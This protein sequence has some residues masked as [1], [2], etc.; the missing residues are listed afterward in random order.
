MIG[1]DSASLRQMIAAEIQRQMPM[2]WA[3]VSAVQIDGGTVNLE[4]GAGIIESVP[5]SSGYPKRQV[6]DVVLALRSPSGNWEVVIKSTDLVAPDYVTADQMESA[7]DDL[8]AD[9]TVPTPETTFGSAAPGAG[10]TQATEVWFQ[11]DGAGKKRTYLRNA[12][13]PP[14]SSPPPKRVAPKSV[15]INPSARGSWRSSGQTDGAVWAGTWT[16]RGNWLGGW[17]YGTDIASACAGRSVKSIL[18]K[19]GRD[20][21]PGRGQAVPVH[22][23]LHDKTSKSKPSTSYGDRRPFKLEPNQTRWW[24]LPAALRD[25]LAS[26]SMR[27]L[28]ATGDGQAEYLRFSSGSGQIKI[29]FNPS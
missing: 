25:D 3:K 5:C 1:P 8:R 28:Y 12:V 14:V 6:G 17:F 26:G 18:I 15:T 7:I 29:N 11:D 20:A 9:L 2:R 27:G 16:S 4:Y 23:G 21:G 19:L 24:T 10:W 13:P 22:I